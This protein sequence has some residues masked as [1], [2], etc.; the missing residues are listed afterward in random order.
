MA[1]GPFPSQAEDLVPLKSFISF[2]GFLLES[3]GFV[4]MRSCCL[5]IETLYFF[6]SSPDGFIS[7]SC[8]VAGLPSAP[9]IFNQVR[10]RP[11]GI[12][13]GDRLPFGGRARPTCLPKPHCDE[14]SQ[15][16]E[17]RRGHRQTLFCSP[18]SWSIFLEHSITIS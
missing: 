1:P 14:C 2:G 7:F 15:A 12:R 6:L 8:L 5:Q 4:Y 9:F 13:D 16:N 17:Q 18:P 3:L 10:T 11:G